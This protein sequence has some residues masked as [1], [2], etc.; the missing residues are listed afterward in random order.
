MIPALACLTADSCNC[1][2]QHRSLGDAYVKEEFVAHKKATPEQV[3]SAS[4]A[5]HTCCSSTSERACSSE[6]RSSS[7][8]CLPRLAAP[9]SAPPLPLPQP[10]RRHRL[11]AC[12]VNT[13]AWT[14]LERAFIRSDTWYAGCLQV[15]VFLSEWGKYHAMIIEQGKANA[16]AEGSGGDQFGANMSAQALE[17]MNDEQRQQLMELRSAAYDPEAKR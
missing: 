9:A 16:T 13:S 6:G 14:F 1:W 17:E 10:Q 15:S 7:A 5:M 11:A 3:R 4:A 12:C 2:L 8:G